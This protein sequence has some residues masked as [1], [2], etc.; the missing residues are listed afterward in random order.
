MNVLLAID[1]SE[2]SNKAVRFV[3]HVFGR[4]Q[5]AGVDVTLFHVVDSLPEFVLDRA[6]SQ[7]TFRHVAQE[8]FE[9]SRQAGEALL[10][11][12]KQAL[13]DDGIPAEAIHTKLEIK[14]GLPEARKVVAALAIIDQMQRG[15]YQ[16]VCVGRRG[17]SATAGQFPGSVAEKVLRE[18]Q[19][20]TVWVVD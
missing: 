13:I 5:R 3:G 6:D 12:Q 9:H 18:A 15:D 16:V 4:G 20:R 17:T 11:R 8:W 19:G 2:A 1:G 10:E 7:E 14:Q